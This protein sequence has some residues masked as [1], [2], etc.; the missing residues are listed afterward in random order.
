VKLGRAKTY[1][2]IQAEEADRHLAD[3]RVGRIAA[4]RAQPT[5]TELDPEGLVLRPPGYFVQVE[6]DDFFSAARGTIFESS[7]ANPIATEARLFFFVDSAG[8]ITFLEKQ[9]GCWSDVV[10]RRAGA[11]ARRER[12]AAR[13]SAK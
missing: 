1:E 10:A 8:E 13:A 12:L 11:V 9:P 3:V 4:A 6:T 7:S 2:E 5:W